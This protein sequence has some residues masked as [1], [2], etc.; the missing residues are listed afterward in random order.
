MTTI[1]PNARL[2]GVAGAEPRR[3]ENYV[4][5]EWVMGTGKATDL[6]HAVTGDK[7]AEATTNG[8]HD[9]RHFDE[10]AAAGQV[11]VRVVDL[12]ETVEVDEEQR[13]RSSAS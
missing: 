10:R 1:A 2:V 9:G 4:C 5:G 12:F 6:Y 7:I 3:L 11:A 8:V 13:Q